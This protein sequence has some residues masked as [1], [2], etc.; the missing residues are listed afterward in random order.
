VFEKTD[1][2]QKSHRMDVVYSNI[3]TLKKLTYAMDRL[4]WL[5]EQALHIKGIGKATV[6]ETFLYIEDTLDRL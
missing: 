3:A 6:E 5:Q 4:G 2:A 1:F